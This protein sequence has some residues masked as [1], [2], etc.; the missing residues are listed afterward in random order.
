MEYWEAAIILEK[1][2]RGAS[3]GYGDWTKEKIM[4][5]RCPRQY[6]NYGLTDLET[7]REQ[8][9]CTGKKPCAECWTRNCPK[10]MNLNVVTFLDKVKQLK[11][12]V[13]MREILQ[14]CPADYGLETSSECLFGENT[15]YK[16]WHREYEKSA[17]VPVEEVEEELN[18]SDLVESLKRKLEIA[19][20]RRNRR[21]QDDK[22]NVR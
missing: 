8:T 9:L 5:S 1:S 3:D 22:K 16:C 11:P 15:C 14:N 10:D 2:C 18:V 12:N 4:R 6:N 20:E 21:I 7:C 13:S 17:T 19:E